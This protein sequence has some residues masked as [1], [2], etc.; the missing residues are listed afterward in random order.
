MK[1]TALTLAAILSLGAA[2]AHA[3]GYTAPAMEP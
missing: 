2:T 3:G 1:K